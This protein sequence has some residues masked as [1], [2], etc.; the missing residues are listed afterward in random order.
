[1]ARKSRT[2]IQE[3]NV[4]SVYKQHMYEAGVYRRLSVEADGDDEELHSIGNQQKIAEDYV[5]QQPHVHIKKIY[6]DNGV[7]GM[8]FQRD[9]FL[10]MMNDLYAGV[11]NCIIVKDISRLGRHFILT[12]EL[13]EK[14]CHP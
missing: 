8:T 11:I 4:V 2:E 14:H 6:T 12:S 10:E 5:I 9:G 7:S 3:E 1:M 13:V